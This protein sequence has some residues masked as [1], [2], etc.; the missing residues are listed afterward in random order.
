MIKRL[1]LA[2]GLVAAVVGLVGLVQSPSA[3]AT[4]N[5]EGCQ[6]V[7]LESN[8]RQNFVPFKK[9][10][11]PAAPTFNDVCG[12]ENDTYTIP[13]TKGVEYKVKVDGQWLGEQAAGTYPAL[14]ESEVY[15]D[16]SAWYYKIQGEDKWTYEFTDV[17][18]VAKISYSVVCDEDSKE[19]VVTFVNSGDGDGTAKLN[20]EEI[21]VAAGSSVERRVA[22]GDEG[23]NVKIELDG[24]VVL[25][26]LFFCFQGQGA[27]TGGDTSD[28]E[29]LPVTS[30]S[31]IAGAAAEVVALSVAATVGGYALQRRH[32]FNA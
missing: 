15:A 16:E 27:V 8:A 12:T 14:G 5:W 23:A 7:V 25:D 26:R 20:D 29:S 31:A 32:A 28:V 22:T 1:L 30:G 6:P 13:E 4:N 17:E 18:C 11:T 24:K 21:A 2:T 9:C 10:V 3:S 19:A